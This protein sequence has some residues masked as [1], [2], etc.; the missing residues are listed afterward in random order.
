MKIENENLVLAKK[1][2]KKYKAIKAENDRIK[3][4]EA[5]I[6]KKRMFLGAAK[7]MIEKKRFGEQLK[8]AEREARERQDKDQFRA[9]YDEE[10]KRIEKSIKQYNSRRAQAV[11]KRMKAEF[12]RELEESKKELAERQHA[13]MLRKKALFKEERRLAA[14]GIAHRKTCK[15]LSK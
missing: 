5:E 4:E 8:G 15:F 14:A 12:S 13:E 1:L 11:Q 3:A 7:S 6:E 2:D 9:K 10:T